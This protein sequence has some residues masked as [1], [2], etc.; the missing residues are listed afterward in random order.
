MENQKTNGK[1]PF[2]KGKGKSYA[3]YQRNRATE[4]EI[5]K[6]KECANDPD[7]YLG[8][9]QLAKDVASFSFNNRVGGPI[10][11]N[12]EALT[13]GS[14]AM[15][16]V[17]SI[18]TTPSVGWSGGQ[19]DPTS[20]VNFAATALYTD[21]RHMNSGHAN[22]ERTDL[23]MYILGVDSLY[24]YISWLTRIYGCLRR[25]SQV[26]SYVGDALVQSMGVDATSVRENYAQLRA[27]I[28]LLIPRVNRLCVP[29]T[30][31]YF[32]RH[33]WMY[34]NIYKD[35]DV[36]KAQLYMYNPAFL[37]EYGLDT[38]NVGC[39]YPYSVCATHNGTSIVPRT[40][41]TNPLTFNDLKNIGER[42]LSSLNSHEDIG[43]ISGDIKKCYGDDGL[44]TMSY[45]EENY[46]TPIVFSEEVLAQIHNTEF[47]GLFPVRGTAEGEWVKGL[48]CLSVTQSTG[49]GFPGMIHQPTFYS[50]QHLA[51]THIFDYWKND[52]PPEMVLV[53]SRNMIASKYNRYA[54]GGFYTDVYSGSE[55]PLCAVVFC[56][57]GTGTL[58]ATQHYTSATANGANIT[59]TVQRF[60]EYP[61][62]YT[63]N[64]GALNSIAGEFSNYTTMSQNDVMD[65]HTTALL[66]LFGV[67]GSKG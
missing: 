11:L 25:F 35:E 16:G 36:D 37:F 54:N 23:M 30:F 57:D 67:T 44:W 39:L 22:Y 9:Q 5:R 50:A 20:P 34:Q 4:V 46:E 60:N 56:Y 12:G 63:M 66:S 2:S 18:L 1:K 43:I 62:C 65:M 14:G 7:W 21:V 28:N 10:L 13:S 59:F 6:P 15:P 61:R 29:K 40:N 48:D 32:L 64:S 3:K 49:I 42:L 51:Y 38:N 53:G 19:G 45:L 24:S 52:V 27:Q 17:M 26:N 8:S 33:A 55:I 58:N 41:S 47:A 31:K